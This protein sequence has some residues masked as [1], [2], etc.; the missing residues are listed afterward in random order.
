MVNPWER[1]QEKGV[2]LTAAISDRVMVDHHRELDF[3]VTTERN[4]LT[5][6]HIWCKV[7]E[8][9]AAGQGGRVPSS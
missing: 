7:G 9:D 4:R 5:R 8:P 6:V 2:Q 1:L 3:R